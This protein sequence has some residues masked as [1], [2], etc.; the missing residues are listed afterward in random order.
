MRSTVRAHTLVG[1]AIT[2]SPFYGQF[3]FITWPLLSHHPLSLRISP[4]SNKALFKAA[5]TMKEPHF[6]EFYAYSGAPYRL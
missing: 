1:E 6:S 4:G 5:T 3:L 2:T